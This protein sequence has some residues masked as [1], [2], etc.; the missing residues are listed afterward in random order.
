[1]VLQNVSFFLWVSFQYSAVRRLNLVAAK[2]AGVGWEG[3]PSE[4]EIRKEGRERGKE[5]KVK[6]R[7]S[8]LKCE[9]SQSAQ[10]KISLLV[11]CFGFQARV[12]RG[13]P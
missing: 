10:L 5:A 3:Y 7:A 6:G 8:F 2:T 9:V 12:T 1:M 11:L 13:R 4:G